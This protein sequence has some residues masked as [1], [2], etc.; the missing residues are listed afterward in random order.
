M[1]KIIIMRSGDKKSPDIEFDEE[2][3]GEIA[4]RLRR[5]NVMKYP[6]DQSDEMIVQRW[7][8]HKIQVDVNGL[9]MWP[10]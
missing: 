10:I 4:K 5:M 2:K 1:I 7:L 8:Q 6:H 9:L 3:C